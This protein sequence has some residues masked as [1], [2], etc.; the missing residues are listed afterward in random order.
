VLSGRTPASGVRPG[1]LI[2]VSLALLQPACGSPDPPREAASGTPAADSSPVANRWERV[3][4]FSGDGDQETKSFEIDGGALQWRV[5]AECSG[6]RLRVSLPGPGEPLVEP[7]CPG[8]GFGFSIDPGRHSLQVAAAG[9][10]VVTVDQ[11]LNNPIAEPPLEGM[12]EGSL[13]AEGDFYDIDQSGTGKAR[14]YRLPDRRL[15]LRFDP[16]RVTSNSDLFVWIS[17]AEAP[18]TSEEAFN[19][20]HLQIASLKSTGGAQNYLL[21]ADLAEDEI[22]SVV[23]WCEPIQVAYA[24]ARLVRS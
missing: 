11:Q 1:L 10:W 14:L 5:T 7:E 18:S 15:A 13:L 22:G 19:S 17:R 2:L 24:A 4:R 21:P 6:P 16:F 9:S 8:T 12:A 23:I 3:A 20:E